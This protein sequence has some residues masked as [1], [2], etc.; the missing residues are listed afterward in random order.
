MYGGV[1]FLHSSYHLH[2]DSFHSPATQMGPGV[3]LW[4]RNSHIY[5]KGKSYHINFPATLE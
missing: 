3:S 5:I 2:L 4:M 1:F